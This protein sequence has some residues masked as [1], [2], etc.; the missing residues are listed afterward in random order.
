MAIR[1]SIRLRL[2]LWYMALLG[3]AL[4]AFSL[5][6]FFMMS[7]HLQEMT[8]ET[9]NRHAAHV[10]DTLRAAS[11]DSPQTVTLLEALE[12][13]A[14]HT[15]VLSVRGESLVQNRPGHVEVDVPAGML[16]QARSG[17]EARFDAMTSDGRTVRALIRPL[18]L[19][20]DLLL[21]VAA[22]K[23][24]AGR[25]LSR[26]RLA[27]IAGSL[28]VLLLGFAASSSVAGEALRPVA[29]MIETARAI[30]LSKGF[31]RRIEGIE[32][33]DELGK[34][35]GTFNQMLASL[36]EAYEGQKRFI[37]DASHELRAPLA[38]LMGN[39]DLLTQYEGI[40]PAER[41]EVLADLRSET[42]RMTRLVEDLL[43]LARA[44]AGQTVDFQEVDLDQLV[45]E[46]FRSVKVRAGDALEVRV[47]RLEAARVIGDK[48]R[49]K[50][51]LVILSDNALGYTPSGGRITFD[52]IVRGEMAELSVEDTGI[53]IHPEDLPH[54]F[55]RF[56]RADKARSRTSG[57]TGLGLSIAQWIA[58][59]HGGEIKVESEPNRGS[60]FTLALPITEPQVSAE[61]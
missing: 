32:R 6:L 58:E 52:L 3:G 16:Q 24:D 50:Q 22:D 23:E 9:I 43:S 11:L 4:V 18:H 21:L 56:Y 26:L 39:L 42:Q 44:D 31:S 45:M 57:G 17:D 8:E 51:L 60:R 5:L 12:A 28:I 14:L 40:P 59:I 37:A 19:D 2:T 48:D 36:E 35:A 20:S 46:I 49:L 33:R 13:P 29:N 55:E 27:L 25:T 54:V 53:G 1:L 7:S 34:L 41:H 61:I 15:E 47:D 30:A 38:T 10:V